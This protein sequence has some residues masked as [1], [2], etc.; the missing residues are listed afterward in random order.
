[1]RQHLGFTLLITGCCELVWCSFCAVNC[2]L[3]LQ[4][5]LLLH[6]FITI[7]APSRVR[8]QLFSVCSQQQHFGTAT[9]CSHISPCIG[10]SIG[11][12]SRILGMVQFW[13]LD[14]FSYS[15]QVNVLEKTRTRNSYHL[16]FLTPKFK[17]MWVWVGVCVWVGGAFHSWET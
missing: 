9:T 4:I 5:A 3:H 13:I 17:C 12:L 16:P 10:N 11:C 8:R 1:M 6:N 7:T 14:C 2:Q 15:L